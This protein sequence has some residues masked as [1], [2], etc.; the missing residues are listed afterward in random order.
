[1]VKFL[2]DGALL[3]WPE[4]HTDH[5]V[6]ALVE[7]R[8]VVGAMLRTRG[9]DASLVVRAHVGEAITGSFGAPGNE[10]FDIVG[11]AVVVA[12]RLEA[13]TVTLSAE[14]FRKLSPEARRR[15]KRQR[16]PAIYIPLEDPRP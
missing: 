8:E 13:R 2:G 16:P 9:L 10:Q 4:E 7:L 14:A 15:F 3:V 1:V 12:A 11:A 6:E 5:A